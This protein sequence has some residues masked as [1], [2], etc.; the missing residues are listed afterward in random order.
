MHQVDDRTRAVL[1]RASVT[2]DRVHITE[3]LDPDAWKAAA[4]VLTL[5]GGRYATN[6]SAY[7]FTSDPREKLRAVID[8]GIVRTEAEAEGYVAT[9]DGLA[10]ELTT[11]PY[12]EIQSLPKGAVV[13][14]PSFGDGQLARWILEANRDVRIVAVE[15]NTERAALFG[16]HPQVTVVNSTFEQFA[17]GATPGEFD[18]VVMN[19][20]F[21]QPGK[22]TLW[23]DHVLGAWD[24]LAAGGRLVAVVPDSLRDGATLRHKD[25]RQLVDDFGGYTKLP[26]DTFKGGFKTGV[27]W[28]ARPIKGQEGRPPYLF[29][30]YPEAIEPVRVTEPWVTTRAVQEAPVQVWADP[31]N[32]RK[33]R[34][35]RFRASCWRCGWLLWEF[36][37]DNDESLGAHSACT[38]LYAVEE[39]KAGL[40]V[41]LCLECRNTE[42]TWEAALKVAR[43]V[44]S[45]PPSKAAPVPVWAL[46][47]RR[48]G[49]VPVDAVERER[50]ARVQAAMR[51]VF[52][53][54][55][56]AE[57]AELIDARNARPL[58]GGPDRLAA[59][60]LREYAD[61]LDPDADLDDVDRAALLWRSDADAPAVPLAPE[62]DPWGPVLDQLELDF[63]AL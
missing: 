53:V 7:V 22:P 24:L 12:S 39:G 23:I 21:S 19:P 4:K 11:H 3:R 42:E 43:E 55:E 27:M 10:E 30:H 5:L 1:A 59:R 41:G 61:R 38:S 35:L 37:G 2:R 58:R 48:G 36:D 26:K 33:D 40:T 31:W 17:A 50:Y 49:M 32:G 46:L 13:L 25:I 47:L 51:A 29:R 44:W 56:H 52:D 45:K 6:Q 20:P 60:Y 14:E 8:T 15:P 34:V 9:P 62:P 57:E 28:L 16:V 54:D 63:T 18:A